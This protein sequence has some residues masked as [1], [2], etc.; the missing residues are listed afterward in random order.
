MHIIAAIVGVIAILGVWYWRLKAARE[1][2]AEVIDAAQ[3]V[4]GA[5]RRRAFRRK[6]ES[7][8]VAAVDDPVIGAA[9]LLV[10]IAEERSPLD[11]GAARD[12]GDW[13]RDVAGL[14]DPTEA[15]TFAR[16]AVSQSIGADTVTDRLAPLFA[17]T[18]TVSQRHDLA[19]KAL[20]LATSIPVPQRDRIIRRI[21]D[22]ICPQ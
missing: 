12:I 13:L 11:E 15:L 2:G 8:P 16:W 17:R 6:A 5:L 14:T 21:R 22:R 4:R 1:V 10:A 18:L 20:D 9:V 19:D 7:S 3:T